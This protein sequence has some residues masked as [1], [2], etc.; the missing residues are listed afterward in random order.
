MAGPVADAPRVQPVHP[1]VRLEDARKVRKQSTSNERENIDS[2]QRIQKIEL[3]WSKYKSQIGPVKQVFEKG[4]RISRTRS[5]ASPAMGG[6]ALH[7]NLHSIKEECPS[8]ANLSPQRE[9]SQQM[10]TTL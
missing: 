3:D 6:L 5:E 2:K 9:S 8:Q 4:E 7:E 1:T 10:R